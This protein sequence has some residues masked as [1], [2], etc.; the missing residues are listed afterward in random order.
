MEFEDGSQVLAK[1]E[2][3]YTL[4]EDLPKK[5]KRRLVS[6]RLTGRRINL[7]PKVWYVETAWKQNILV[8]P[9]TFSYLL[10]AVFSRLLLVHGLEHAFPGCLLHHAGGEET[11][12]DTQLSL[13]ERLCGPARPPY[14]CQKHMG[15]TQPQREMKSSRRINDKWMHWVNSGCRGEVVCVS[16]CMSMLVCKLLDLLPS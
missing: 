4:D 14:N 12:E 2:D 6:I 5:V 3:V 13:P 11:T 15:A 1:R 7:K 10:I 8:P 9:Q 16:G